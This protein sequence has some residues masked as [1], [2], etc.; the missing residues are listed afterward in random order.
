VV[1]RSTLADMYHSSHGGRLVVMHALSR[2][3]MH[4]SGSSTR[5]PPDDEHISR[6]SR[7]LLQFDASGKT[8]VP[9]PKGRTAA[10]MVVRPA[11]G[12]FARR[13]QQ[14]DRYIRRR[15]AIEVGSIHDDLMILTREPDHE[16]AG[17]LSKRLRGNWASV[18][19][20]DK[21]V[22]WDNRFVLVAA[23]VSFLDDP[24]ASPIDPKATVL[25]ALELPR[26]TNDSDLIETS[27]YVRQIRRA[28]WERVTAATD[29]VRSFHIPFQ[30]IRALPAIFQKSVGETSPGH[31]VASPHLGLSS[32]PDLFFT[33]VRVPRFRTLP[34]EIEPGFCIHSFRNERKRPGLSEEKPSIRHRRE[35]SL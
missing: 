34:T 14:Q 16:S 4:V 9:L 2:M 25:A 28:D 19:L 24:D 32:R 22:Y 23:P 3:I 29:R 35:S 12:R 11:T 8:L 30:C 10:G 13:L 21:P 18:A 7:D 15:P 6:L 17:L 5:L 26:E 1:R 27:L 31:L 20:N 33:A